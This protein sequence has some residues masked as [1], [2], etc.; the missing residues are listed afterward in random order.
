MM[1]LIDKNYNP[2]M[3]K[4][5]GLENMRFRKIIFLKKLFIHIIS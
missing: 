1:L 3:K 5:Y 4:E 2:N